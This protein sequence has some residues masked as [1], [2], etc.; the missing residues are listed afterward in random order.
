MN[1]VATPFVLRRAYLFAIALLMVQLV[2]GA[3]VGAIVSIA[4]LGMFLYWCLTSISLAL[5]AALLVS[6]LG[7]WRRIGFRPSQRPVVDSLLWVP[8]CP[9]LAWNVY[10]IDFDSLVTPLRM[11][12]LLLLTA[13]A[14]FVEEVYFRGLMLRALESKGVWRAAALSAVLFGLM[15]LLNALAGSDLAMTAGRVAYAAAIGFAYAAYALHTGLIWPLI[16]V[17]AL[18]NFADLID[19]ETIFTAEAPTEADLIRWLIY[20]VIFTIYG[21]LM[22]RS[23]TRRSSAKVS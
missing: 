1:L 14:A 17:H 19:Q 4:N 10:Q 11:V 8:L 13:L 15:H 22:L 20:V 2:V 5:I 18:A 23:V 12:G 6:W 21:S 3:L 9:I 7:W 16:L